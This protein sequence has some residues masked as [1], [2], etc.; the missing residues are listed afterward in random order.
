MTEEFDKVW[1]RLALEGTCDSRG[2][3][4]YTRVLYEWT[5]IGRPRPVGPFIAAR[6]NIQ[7]N[8]SGPADQN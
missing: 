3:M 5:A 6:A 1:D 4:E 7:A 8:G 2:G